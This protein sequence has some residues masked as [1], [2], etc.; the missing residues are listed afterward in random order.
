MLDIPYED[1][2]ALSQPDGDENAELNQ[3]KE[4]RQRRRY[5]MLSET[6]SLNQREPDMLES[7]NGHDQAEK[8]NLPPKV[9]TKA[10]QS[11]NTHP[12]KRQKQSAK[13]H[14]Q[15]SFQ[16]IISDHFAS[17]TLTNGKVVESTKYCVRQRELGSLQVREIKLGETYFL[18]V[19]SSTNKYLITIDELVHCGNQWRAKPKTIFI[20]ITTTYYLGEEGGKELHEYLPKQAHLEAKFGHA[21]FCHTFV[22]KGVFR[23]R[24]K[25]TF[26]SPGWWT[27]AKSHPLSLLLRES[28]NGSHNKDEENGSCIS[29][30]SSR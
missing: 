12:K 14:P 4:E 22:W 23:R 28:R 18:K 1:F 30:A 5:L 2:V 10:K 26:R 25:C 16:T 15:S 3:L 19:K 27:R 24:A 6:H 11:L 21:I 13:S 9:I 29:P 20:D 8:E 17:K 7:I